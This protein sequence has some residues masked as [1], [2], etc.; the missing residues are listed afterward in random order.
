METSDQLDHLQREHCEEIQGYL[1]SE[2]IPPSD[3]PSL[4]R[5]VDRIGE[6]KRKDVDK[7]KPSVVLLP[8]GEKKLRAAG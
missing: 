7:D 2:P 1:Y 6:F 4:L 5:S 3:I 8:V